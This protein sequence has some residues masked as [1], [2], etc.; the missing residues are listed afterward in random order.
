MHTDLAYLAKLVPNRSLGSNHWSLFCTS[1]ASLGNETKVLRVFFQEPVAERNTIMG[2]CCSCCGADDD[3]NAQGRQSKGA[4]SNVRETE[5]ANTQ[6]SNS[7]GS[8]PLSIS[9][10]MSSPN[11]EVENDNVVC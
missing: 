3:D 10:A 2:G 4:S 5:M 8:N 7:S 1:I 9:R 6:S 11:I